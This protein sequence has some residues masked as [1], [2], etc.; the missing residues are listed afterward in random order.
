VDSPTLRQSGTYT[1]L[2]EG[3][4][5]AGSTGTYS[6]NVQPYTIATTPL[7]LGSQVNGSISVAGEHPTRC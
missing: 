3:P 7:T 6:F 5:G 4:L 1:L 2:M